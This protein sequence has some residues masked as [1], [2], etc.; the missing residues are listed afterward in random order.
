MGNQEEQERILLQVEEVQNQLQTF[1]NRFN[2]LIKALSSLDAKLTILAKYITRMVFK[3]HPVPQQKQAPA[4][5][6]EMPVNPII[7][8]D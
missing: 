5:N 7:D 3:M 1:N 2:V 6:S 8:D 4:E